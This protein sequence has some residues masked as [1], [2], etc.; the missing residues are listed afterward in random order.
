MSQINNIPTIQMQKQ[1]ADKYKNVP[2]EYLQVAE[3]MESQFTNH[4]LN[5]MRKS[6]KAPGSSAERIYRSML[7][8]ERSKLMAQ[9]NTGLGIK[10]VVLR[11]IYPN[12]DKPNLGNVKMYKEISKETINSQQGERDE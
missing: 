11:E 8:A 6:V 1:D 4:L 5:E 3:G 7:D 9:T 12:F 2:K 10:D